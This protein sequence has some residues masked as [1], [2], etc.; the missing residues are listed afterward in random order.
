PT[1][2]PPASRPAAPPASPNPPCPSSR[3]PPCARPDP[4]APPRCRAHASKTRPTFGSRT[5][6]YVRQADNA[7]PAWRGEESISPTSTS[8][9]LLP[10]SPPP[11]LG[12]CQAAPRPDT[13]RPFR[14]IGL[15]DETE[16]L[17]PPPPPAHA[18]ELVARLFST[19]GILQKALGLEHR[20]QQEHMARAVADTFVGDRPLL[21]EAG[22]GVGK[23][24]A[25]LLP[26]IIHAIDQSRQLV[27]S[28]HTIALQEQ[29]DRK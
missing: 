9:G 14:M 13:F 2:S 20:P 3:W 1:R 18:P 21:F 12:D 11:P 26:G 24:L 6:A 8:S 19:G 23:S 4:A 29:L 15:N 16:N 28:T 22:T 5:D 27:V 17:A 25:Y 7:L 10:P